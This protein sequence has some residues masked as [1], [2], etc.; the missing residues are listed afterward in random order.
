MSGT[1]QSQAPLH[2]SGRSSSMGDELYSE[3]LRLCTPDPDDAADIARLAGDPIVAQMTGYIPTPYP[4]LAA[5][6]WLLIKEVRRANPLLP[7]RGRHFTIRTGKADRL[8]GSIAVV[9]KKRETHYEIG[10]WIARS[11]WGNGYA[12]EAVQ[13][14]L[15]W[16]RS[17]IGI[18]RLE[19]GFFEDNPASG[20][21]L[22]QSGFEF[23]GESEWMFSVARGTKVLTLNMRRP[24]GW[25]DSAKEADSS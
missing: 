8:I 6:M 14:I 11:S 13:A 25:Y 4:V 17:N 20:R 9:E 21:V 19:A 18:G 16:G 5:Q 10:Y 3:N 22:E 7:R 2:K 1:D 24:Y 12:T 23:T 15:K